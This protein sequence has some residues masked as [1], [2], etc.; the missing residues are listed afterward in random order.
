MEH[1]NLIYGFKKLTTKNTE[2]GNITE[3]M[4]LKTRAGGESNTG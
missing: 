4:G 2:E 3:Y 1:N